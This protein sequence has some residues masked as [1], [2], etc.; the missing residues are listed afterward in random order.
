MNNKKKSRLA[1]GY[2]QRRE[3]IV[4]LIPQSRVCQ[5]FILPLS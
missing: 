5:F 1:S 2:F 3:R 4:N